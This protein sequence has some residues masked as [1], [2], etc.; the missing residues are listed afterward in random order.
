MADLYR[1]PADE[2]TVRAWCTDRLVRWDVPHETTVLDTSLGTTHLTS[3]GTGDDVRLYL[4]GTNFNAATSTGVLAALASSARVVC[5]D[6]P[7]Q[8]GLSAAG[9]PR[10]EVPAYSAWVQEVVAHVRTTTATHRL[11]LVG[12]SRGAAAAL[13]ADPASV[14]GLLLLSPAG[15]AGVRMT[16]A[17]VGRSLAWLLRPT[18]ARTRRLVA[19][20]A[21]AADDRGLEDVT[22]W[23]TLTARCTRTTGAPGPLPGHL[24][25]RWRER[26][27]AVLSGERDVFF[28]PARLA[29]PTLRHLGQEVEPVPGAG[30]LL[31]DQRPDL[32]AD[33]AARLLA[34][35]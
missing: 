11:L 7:G 14:D 6:L 28:P 17:V 23:L 9:R 31:V 1:S 15:L 22:E 3:A 29:G 18:P 35:D 20:M 27:V 30:H 32:V 16:P 4:P 33:R 5:A 12:H 19:L 8:P 2:S 25:E 13:G 10:D 34:R 21:G 26:P 24:V